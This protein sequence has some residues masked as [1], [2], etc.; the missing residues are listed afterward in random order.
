MQSKGFPCVHIVPCNLHV[1]SKMN[2]LLPCNLLVHGKGNPCNWEKPLTILG[3]HFFNNI[4]SLCRIKDFPM[5]TLYPLLPCK[6]LQCRKNYYIFFGDSKTE[7]FIY[8]YHLH[9]AY[10][11]YM[12]ICSLYH[13]SALWND[14]MCMSIQIP[15]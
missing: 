2:P 15:T 3:D 6:H 9:E 11:K 13:Y 4:F 14:A 1:Y 5:F 7:Y 10:I 8:G 12:L